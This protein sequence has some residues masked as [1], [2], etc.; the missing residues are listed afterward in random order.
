LLEQQ[1]LSNDDR[2]RLMRLAG[3][4]EEELRRLLQS[5]Q[6]QKI[7][8]GAAL[9]PRLLF[10]VVFLPLAAVPDARSGPAD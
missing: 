10:L 6:I 5:R 1:N 7:F 3:E 8:L 2:R 9:K 4:A